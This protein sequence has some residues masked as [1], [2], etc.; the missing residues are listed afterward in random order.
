MQIELI[1][2]P[3]GQMQIDL[4]ALFSEMGVVSAREVITEAMER[5]IF[6]DE[7]LQQ[8]QIDGLSEILRR[9]LKSEDA[10]G[11]P[12]AK[13]I[14]TGR[15]AKWKQFVLLDYDEMAGSIERDAKGL[16]ADYEK[17]KR[18]RDFCLIK[19]GRAPEIPALMVPEL[20]EA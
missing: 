7:V 14:S 13:P 12:F 16:A 1:D 20:V 4:R 9:A 2:N 15:N 10:N 6:P 17:V 3:R 5:G 8:A 19:F 18:Q 11:L